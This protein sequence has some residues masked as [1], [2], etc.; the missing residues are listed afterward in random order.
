MWPKL[1]ETIDLVIFTGE[2]LNGRLHFLCSVSR[3]NQHWT[4]NH[5]FFFQMFWKYGLSKNSYWNM[6]FL[7]LK[8]MEIW[9]F[10]QL[11]WDGLSKKITLEYDLSSIR[12]SWKHFPV[13]FTENNSNFL[14]RK[15][16]FCR[17]FQHNPFILTSRLLYFLENSNPLFILVPC[18]VYSAPKSTTSIWVFITKLK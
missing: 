12:E 15:S 8:Y 13:G 16:K 5:I 10:L 17:K 6:I 11:F 4:K 14:T 1:Q 18:P 7:A 3:D 9:Y 2:I